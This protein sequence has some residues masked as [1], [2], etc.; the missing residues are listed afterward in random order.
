MKVLVLTRSTM[1]AVADMV[2]AELNKRAVPVHRLDPGDFPESLST[3][4]RIGPGQ[5]D[6]HGTWRAQY[7]D[8][9][10]EEITAVYYRRP[11]P[12]QLHPDL[13]AEDAQWAQGEARAG[14]GGIL[15]SLRCVWVNHPHR[16]AVA[17]FA[18]VAL[19]TASRC[20]LR[21]PRTVITNDL[22]EARDF[23]N[24][25]PDQVAAYKS[26]GNSGPSTYEGQE[27]ALWTTQ[28]RPK[29]ITKDIA[30]T[31]HQFQEWID[32]K[33]EVRLTVVAGRMFAAEIRAGSEASRIDFRRDYDSLT[34]RACWVPD[35]VAHGVHILM[36]TF[37][38]RYAA[39]DFLVDHK[40]RW[41]LVD[42]NPNGQ[43][44]FIP[45]L[46]EP[47]THALADL[48]EGKHP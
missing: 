47:I 44:G 34:Y 42:L 11:S 12:F 4:A 29:E 30:R 27:Y 20:G 2:I 33:F 1:D 13:S 32:K 7:R 31:A 45:E 37:G 10:L 46:Q 43:F 18:P 14:F 16:N 21:V 23:I 41:Y 5:A 40:D 48:L 19:A 6:W 8:F 15:T 22:T 38:L 26:L 24:T 9:R 28:V 39:L 3:T 25:L 17:D 35:N 36:D